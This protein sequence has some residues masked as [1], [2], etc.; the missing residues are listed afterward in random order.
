MAEDG[1]RKLRVVEGA[2]A[3]SEDRVGEYLAALGGRSASTV[4]ATGGSY[5]S[6]PRGPSRGRVALRASGRSF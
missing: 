1:A 4:D 3:G 6:S 2:E 5:A